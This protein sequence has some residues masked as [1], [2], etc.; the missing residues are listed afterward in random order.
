MGRGEHSV[1][2][3]GDQRAATGFAL[4]SEMTSDAPVR[5]AAAPE[6]SPPVEIALF[7]DA[8]A[9]LFTVADRRRAVDPTAPWVPSRRYV[10]DANE[11]D[12]IALDG[13]NPIV[14]MSLDDLIDCSVRPHPNASQLVAIAGVHRGFLRLMARPEI[15]SIA[16][17]RGRRIAVD[18]DTGYA[19]ALHEILR[20]AGIDRHRDVEIVYAGATDR[21]NDKLLRGEFDAT[22]LGAPFTRMAMANGFSSLTSVIGALGGY[23][24]VVLLAHR[25]WLAQN[26]ATARAVTACLSET[27]SWCTNSANRTVLETYVGEALPSVKGEELRQVTE[28][29]FG[30][31]T[32]FL[33]NG[34]MRDRDVSVVLDLFN[35]SRGTALTPEAVTRLMPTVADTRGK[36]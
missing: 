25:P 28:D 13:P 30:T 21:R 4:A 15:G 32:E 7:R 35:A 3:T 2:T 29:L 5:A 20:R 24:A 10:T 33:L 18:T 19:S 27:L 11:A 1:S 6:A 22:L 16:A 17:L 14:G 34:R 26:E 8:T 9:V 23:Q 36:F 31:A 12:G